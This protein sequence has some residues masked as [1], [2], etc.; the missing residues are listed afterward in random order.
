MEKAVEYTLTNMS[1]AETIST[2]YR[3]MGSEQARDGTKPVKELLREN[4]VNIFFH[5][6][7]HFFGKQEK[8]CLVYQET[9]QP[10][11]P[12]YL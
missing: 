5:G 6:H 11:H 3:R 8:D 1:G 2:R 7:D 10:S 4:R 9:P 12:N